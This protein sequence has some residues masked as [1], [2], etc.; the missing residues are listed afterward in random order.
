MAVTS[1]YSGGNPNVTGV[2][3]G[4][5]RG[6]SVGGKLRFL[7]RDSALYGGAAAVSKAFAL[8]TFPLLARHFSTVDYGIVDFFTVVAGLLAILIIF[9]QDSAVARYFYE[10]EDL[11]R[12]R[13]LI[14]Q[15]LLMQLLIGVVVVGV[16]WVG[17]GVVEPLLTG[18]SGAG[19]YF[20]IILLQAPLMVIIN[21][22]QNLL[23]WTFSRTK[24]LIMTMGFMLTSVTLL[25]VAILRLAGDIRTVL[26][27]NLLSLAIFAAVGLWFVRGWLG[28]PRGVGE[29]RELVRYAAP[30]GVI[31]VAGTFVP[32][33]ERGLT[34][35][36]LGG[37]QLGLYAAG[38]KVALLTMLVAQAFQVAWGPF[39]LSLFREPDAAETYNWVF[40]IFAAGMAVVVLGL[41]LVAYPM[42]VFLA[43]DR[44]AGAAAVVFPLAVGLAIQATSWITEIGISI[45]KKS[46]LNLYSYGVFV[47]ATLGGIFL[48]APLF[49]LPGV[50]LGVM[51]GHIGKALTASFLA[52][53]V[54]PLPWSYSPAAALGVLVITVGAAGQWATAALGP[55]Q[56]MAAF[57]LGIVAVVSFSLMVLFSRS[58]RMLILAVIRS[59]IGVVRQRIRTP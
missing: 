32:A 26:V 57:G 44:Y 50:A 6:L 8:I 42:L 11:A 1:S 4:E 24:F 10:Y 29:L 16:L 52:Q 53:R 49:G 12:R 13:Q 38:T 34:N 36:L 18:E 21:F 35:S 39:S 27:V 15:S 56:G 23:K 25:L 5:P 40:R 43:S 47:F 7:M 31:C 54:Y 37:E 17:T 9:G 2:T 14:S 3:R 28:V 19:T 22:S 51:L 46:H 33:M 41:S 55:S 59:R 20:R 30:L 48:C 45:S 58:E